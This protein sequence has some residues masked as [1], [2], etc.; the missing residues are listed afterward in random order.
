MGTGERDEY[1]LEAIG[2]I[3][4]SRTNKMSNKSR[5]RPGELGN[6]ECQ[7]ER[8]GS[9]PLETFWSRKSNH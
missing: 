5:Q 1:E 9:S 8:M 3:V 6:G 7:K 4:V 2:R